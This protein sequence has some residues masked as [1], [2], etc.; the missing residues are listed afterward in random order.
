[1]KDQF[2]TSEMIDVVE[3]SYRLVQVKQQKYVCRS[4]WLAL[5]LVRFGS[6]QC[7]L[8]LFRLGLE[9]LEHLQ[10]QL[11]V[12]AAPRPTELATL[13]LDELHQQLQLS[14][15]GERDLAKLLD[16]LLALE[17][18]AL[19]NSLRSRRVIR[20]NCFPLGHDRRQRTTIEQRAAFDEERELALCQPYDLPVIAP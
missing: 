5:A 1:M 13:L 7:R 4:G 2:E 3:V 14:V 6:V 11:E 17:I 16:V 18:A 19:H 9:L 12:T 8:R 20:N 10:R 15:L